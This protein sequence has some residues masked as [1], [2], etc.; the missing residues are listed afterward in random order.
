[1]NLPDH[2]A[3]RAA[4][5]AAVIELLNTI[6]AP[7]RTA[8]AQDQAEAFV[9]AMANLIFTTIKTYIEEESHERTNHH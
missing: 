4:Y 7:K 3:I 2:P 1:M 8:N 6:N 5:Q 9:D